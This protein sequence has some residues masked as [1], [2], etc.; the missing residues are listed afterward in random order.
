MFTIEDLP[1]SIIMKEFGERLD[2]NSDND[3]YVIS[4]NLKKR[5]PLSKRGLFIPYDALL[6]YLNNKLDILFLGNEKYFKYIKMI[7]FK[8]QMKE[9]VDV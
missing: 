1:K 4:A 5:Y 7:M 8:K 9:I 6:D 2:Y 3:G